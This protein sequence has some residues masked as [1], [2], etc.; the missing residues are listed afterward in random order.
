MIDFEGVIIS[1]MSQREKDKYHMI[2]LICLILKNKIKQKQTLRY[3]EQIGGYHW[4]RQGQKR[5]KWL[6]G[7]S[8]MVR[9]GNYTFGSEHAIMN[10]ETDVVHMKLT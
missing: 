7:I 5:M 4:K 3:R 9:N 10:T 6:Q 2:V 1:E 8:S